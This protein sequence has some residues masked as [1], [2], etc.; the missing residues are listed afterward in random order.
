M[1]QGTWGFSFS[2]KHK[3]YSLDQF[4]NLKFRVETLKKT[5]NRTLKRTLKNQHKMQKVK[6][7]QKIDDYLH[8]GLF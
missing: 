3:C 7:S 5:Q 2:Q 6:N 4:K 1:H 8:M